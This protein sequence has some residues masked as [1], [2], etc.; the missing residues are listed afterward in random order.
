M[1]TSSDSASLDERA[2]F[3][4]ALDIEDPNEREAF[5]DQSCEGDPALLT[6]IRELI[7]HAT[8]SGPFLDPAHYP[9]LESTRDAL[10]L[11][12]GEKDSYVNDLGKSITRIGDYELLEQIGRGA[13]GLVFRARQTSLNREVAM[14]II[15][16]SA[17]ASP[18]ERQ[19]FRLE[20]ESAA[21]LDHPSIV[22]VFETGHDGEHDF[23]SMTLMTGGNL[24]ELL[25][26]KGLAPREAAKRMVPVIRAVHEAHQH[27]IIHRDLKPDNILLD[28]EGRF[29]VSDFGTACRL[30]QASNLTLTGQILGTPKYMAP[31]QASAREKEHTTSVD[32]YSLGVILYELLAGSPPFD[33][34]DVLDVLQ[35]AREEPP[36]KISSQNPPVPRDLETIVLKCLEKSP[37][38]RYPSAAAL[39]DDLE[40]WL[41]HKPITARPPGL[42][43]RAVLWMTRHPVHA[44]LAAL[45]IT[46]LLT[47]GIGGPL[48]AINQHKL[49]QEAEQANALAEKQ[50]SAALA[51]ARRNQNLAYDFSTRLTAVA[52]ERLG[53]EHTLAPQ[54]MLDA[55]QTEEAAED[56]RGWEWYYLFGKLYQKPLRLPGSGT[57]AR[58]VRFSPDGKVFATLFHDL[59]G[60]HIRHSLHS[61]KIHEL[62]EDSIVYKSLAWSKDGKLLLLISQE[63]KA[64][65][66]NA[67]RGELMAK[68]PT[69]SPVQAA[70]WLPAPQTLGLYESGGR[71]TTW[72]IHD[73]EHPARVSSIKLAIGGL[74]QLSW[75]SDGRHLAARDG[76]NDAYLW[77]ADRLQEMPSRL[78]G[79]TQPVEHLVWHA[80]GN[81]LATSARDRSIRIWEIPGGA[82]LVRL[83]PHASTTSGLSWDRNGFRLLFSGNVAEHLGLFT[84]FQGSSESIRV[85]TD[86]TT[87][88]WHSGVHSVLCGDQQ[89]MVTLKRHGLPKFLTVI[90]RDQ[91][92]PSRLSWN[93]QGTLLRLEFPDRDDIALDALSGDPAAE[94][95]TFEP[96]S[97]LAGDPP[98]NLPPAVAKS[99]P[100]TS[101]WHPGK[102]RLTTGHKNGVIRIWDSSTNELCLRE[103]T[104][105]GDVAAL[106]WDPSG[107]RLA[108]ATTKGLIIILDASAGIILNREMQ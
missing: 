89:G 93:S 22:K 47:L 107:V 54:V 67:T 82:R 64:S 19:R 96:A 83:G 84:M 13:A 73:R 106:S 46:F 68:P 78:R 16:G 24:A 97:P 5:L 23:F 49:R 25:D 72:S 98:A 101:C 99:K 70:A 69:E 105:P 12:L 77:D 37:A 3:L 85:G 102:R 18:A 8:D 17:L 29:H 62:G 94:D 32:V 38:R 104:R 41:A 15:V 71:L 50:R 59:P 30:E 91:P 34:T 87:F 63:G 42:V 45:G 66:W 35:K 21:T 44:A 11:E 75:S 81:W 92:V 33:G 39:A 79:H 28:E 52:M 20:A 7:H 61:A 90:A 74:Q 4:K 56:P 31:E 43:E 60:V 14:K 95:I 80:N 76:G 10:F 6:R 26:E 40:A 88:D 103:R 1:S 51:L 36:P 27:G 57:P 55:W 100:L 108:I 86:A 48:V 58:M 65:I 2:L 9:D 53:E